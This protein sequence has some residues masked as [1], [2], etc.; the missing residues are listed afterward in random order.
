[1][2]LFTFLPISFPSWWLAKETAE[3]NIT[4]PALGPQEGQ[5][6]KTGNDW[7]FGYNGDDWIFWAEERK[8]V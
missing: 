5:E 3:A 1:L 2:F 4:Q 6:Q 7:S 8:G